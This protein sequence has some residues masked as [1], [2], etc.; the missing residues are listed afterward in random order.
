ML[1][2]ADLQAKGAYTVQHSTI[3]DLAGASVGTS[4]NGNGGRR[5]RESSSRE[6]W[7]DEDDSTATAT[8]GCYND[9]K[10]GGDWHQDFGFDGGSSSTLASIPEEYEE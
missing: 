5:R 10:D 8:D 9:K 4:S 1:R 6:T 7:E 3:P 2:A